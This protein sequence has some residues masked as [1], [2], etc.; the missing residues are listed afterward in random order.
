MFFLQLKIFWK[1][2]RK[3][4][5]AN[6]KAK[7]MQILILAFGLL[8]T[9]AEGVTN[10]EDVANSNATLDASTFLRSSTDLQTEKDAKGEPDG[11]QHT[12]K[13]FWKN[14]L[15]KKLRY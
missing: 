7:T 12:P 5:G 11:F 14:T 6:I 4:S 10:A 2:D 9:N 1:L 13:K 8:L 15:L 3:M